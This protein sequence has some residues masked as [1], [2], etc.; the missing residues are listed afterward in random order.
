MCFKQRCQIISFEKISVERGISALTFVKFYIQ[1]PT[2]LMLMYIEQR[3]ESLR[4][5]ALVEWEFSLYN[6]VISLLDD[7]SV[8]YVREIK[9]YSIFDEVLE[10]IIKYIDCRCI[11]PLSFTIKVGHTNVI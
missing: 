2:V 8:S 9:I 6:S 4:V 5:C 10:R 3:T 1:V 11:R 7:L